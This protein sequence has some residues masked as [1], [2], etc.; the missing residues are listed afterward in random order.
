MIQ[1][2]RSGLVV[3][4]TAADL[5]CL[6]T[7]FGR[8]HCIQ[9]PEFLSPDLL[10][11]IQGR[12]E[13]GDFHDRIHEK[14]GLELCLTQHDV[15]LSLLYLLT[16]DPRLFQLVQ[17]LTGCDRIGCLIGRVYRMVP[18]SGHYDSWHSDT[19]LHRLIGVSINLS[20]ETYEGGVF[21]LRDASSKKI[22]CQ[23][24]NTG[25]GDAIMFRIA[26][27]LEHQITAVTGTASKTAFAGW[28][29]SEPEFR[30]LLVPEHFH[31]S[32]QESDRAAALIDSGGDD[33]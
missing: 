26:D 30:S 11:F 8:Q 24:A 23:A 33:Q 18:G 19:I 14:V 7:Q 21:Q 20:N 25:A 3:S 4:A 9:L 16:N 29:K 32:A 31:E 5:D 13:R 27:P 2:T 12:L 1:V 22:L 10:R 28:F 15:A 17:Q 6:R